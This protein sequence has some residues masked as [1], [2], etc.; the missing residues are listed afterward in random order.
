[1]IEKSSPVIVIGMHRSGT[2]LLARVLH[3]CKVFMGA[4][5]SSHDEA[6]FFLRRNQWLFRLAHAAWDN[7]ESVKYLLH[8]QELR[9]EAVAYLKK[10]LM[11]TKFRDYLGWAKY[12]IYRTLENKNQVW[13]WKDPLTSYTLPLWMDIFPRAKVI[14]VIRNGIDVAN[15]LQTREYVR[16]GRLQ[17]H[18]TSCRCYKLEDAFLLW[19][20]YVTNCITVNNSVP[21]NQVM[22]FRY[23]DF[24]KEPK[25][26][27][28]EV[29]NFLQTQLDQKTI[30]EAVKEIRPNNAYQFLKN[31]ALLRLYDKW[32]DHSL[33]VKFDYDN[34]K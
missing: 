22:Q 1:M 20:E 13:G 11:S 14:H 26:L 15:S 6:Y 21:D 27:L 24:L 7:P 3:Q 8:C 9:S 5:R 17:N 16:R 33:M 23:E 12:L 29:S 32:R 25:K 34:I 31:E 28:E 10:E 30:H 4:R 2:S 19:A 18:L